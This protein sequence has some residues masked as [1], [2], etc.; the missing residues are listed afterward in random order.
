MVTLIKFNMKFSLVC[1][2]LH[3]A[4]WVIYKLFCFMHEKPTDVLMSTFHN[5]DLMHRPLSTYDT[6]S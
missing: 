1:I 6:W 4:L 2:L 5:T 3:A